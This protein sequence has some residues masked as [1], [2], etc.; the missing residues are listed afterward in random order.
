MKIVHKEPIPTIGYVLAIMAIACW[1]PALNYFNS[2]QKTTM[3]SP[4]VS[5]DMNEECTIG[6]F[7]KHDLWHFL[8]AAGLFLNF[9]FLLVI[10]D[11]IMDRP[12][13]EIPIF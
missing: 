9:L 13:N 5:R 7:D 1:I 2:K 4:S 11:G 10:D 6:I 12:R 3:V 8:S